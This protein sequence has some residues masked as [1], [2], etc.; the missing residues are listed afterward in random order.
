VQAEPGVGRTRSGR[1]HGDSVGMWQVH[2]MKDDGYR[3]DKCECK[4]DPEAK[5][6]TSMSCRLGNQVRES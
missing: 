6:L 2:L 1:H 3:E 5:A 4:R